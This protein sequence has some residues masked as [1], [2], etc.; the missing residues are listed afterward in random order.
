MVQTFNPNRRRRQR[1]GISSRHR[2]RNN[3]EVQE[4]PTSRKHT[5]IVI[6]DCHDPLSLTHNE[7][8]SE[9]NFLTPAKAKQ[10]LSTNKLPS[11]DIAPD[12]PMTMPKL[13]VVKQPSVSL[14]PGTIYHPA[15]INACFAILGKHPS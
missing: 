6:S 11:L 9:T 1:S 2:R 14:P 3:R 10:N 5:D 12:D 7:A 4:N 13:S 8:V 15:T